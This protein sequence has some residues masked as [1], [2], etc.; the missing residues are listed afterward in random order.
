MKEYSN[1]KFDNLSRNK[2]IL[3]TEPSYT[4]MRMPLISRRGSN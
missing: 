3:G 1:I 4:N 2:P